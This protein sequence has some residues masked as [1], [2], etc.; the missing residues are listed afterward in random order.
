[1]VSAMDICMSIVREA[2]EIA[3][4]CRFMKTMVILR[5]LSGIKKRVPATGNIWAN[6]RLIMDQA[7]FL[8]MLL[9]PPLL[10]S[11]ILMTITGVNRLRKRLSLALHLLHTHLVTGIHANTALHIYKPKARQVCQVILCIAMKMEVINMFRVA[12]AEALL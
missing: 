7:H 1:M 3:K 10:G 5:I 8:S 2:A 11:V 6:H 4:R 9:Q 12:A